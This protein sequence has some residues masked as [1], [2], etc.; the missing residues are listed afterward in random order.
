MIVI[1]KAIYAIAWRSVKKIQDFN[2]VE[3]VTSQYRC[4][5]LPTEL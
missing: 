4:D 1:V 3:P 5:A 2:G